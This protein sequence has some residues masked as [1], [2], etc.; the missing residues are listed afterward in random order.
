MNLLIIFTSSNLKD[1]SKRGIYKLAAICNCILKM[2]NIRSG[3]M[4]RVFEQLANGRK[5]NRLY[6]LH[7]EVANTE[8]KP[9]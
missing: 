1:P 3:Q 9:N 2:I 6:A 8:S 4:S 5:K 7:I